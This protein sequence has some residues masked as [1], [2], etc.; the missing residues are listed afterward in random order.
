MERLIEA[1]ESVA[2]QLS[3]LHQIL[4]EIREDF[5]WAISNMD[6]TPRPDLIREPAGESMEAND[7]ADEEALIPPHAEG[8]SEP[9]PSSFQSVQQREL[10]GK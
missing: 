1:V 6:R 5:S 8:I 7:L 9:P 2:A 4:D 3:V 10:W